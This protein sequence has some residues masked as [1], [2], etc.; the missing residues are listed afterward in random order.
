[1]QAAMFG[2]DI[3]PRDDTL[4]ILHSY[5]IINAYVKPVDPK[6]KIGEY[7][8][9]WTLNSKTIIEDVPQNENQIDAPTYDIVP[10]NDLETYRGSIGGIGSLI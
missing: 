2:T 8:Y 4:K 1:V 9:Q 7:K 10:F 3:D 5:Y 6:Y